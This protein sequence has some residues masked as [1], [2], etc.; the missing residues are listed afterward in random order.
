M[1]GEIFV[2]EI[3]DVG[4]R[5]FLDYNG[6]NYAQTNNPLTGSVFTTEERAERR[7]RK[8][9]EAFDYSKDRVKVVKF[10]YEETG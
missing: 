6:C 2:I 3:L 4:P 5:I 9:R 1:K 7:A 10:S 8:Y